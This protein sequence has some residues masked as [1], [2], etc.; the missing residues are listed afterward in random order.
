MALVALALVV[1]AGS[2]LLVGRSAAG[3]GAAAAATSAGGTA[4]RADHATQEPLAQARRQAQ[5]LLARMT[6]TQED[7]LLHGLGEYQGPDGSIGT[8]PPSPAWP[9]P[10]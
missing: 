7:D 10:R 2:A 4:C 1:L 5:A 3:A 8:T 9:S 6:L